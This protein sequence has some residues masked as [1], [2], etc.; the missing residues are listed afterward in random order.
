MKKFLC[1]VLILIMAMLLFA[2]C[3]PN[4]IE[5]P[6]EEFDVNIDVDRNTEATLR[7]L[8]PSTDGGQEEMYIKALEPGFKEMFPNVTIEYDRRAISDDK[9]V[10][11][12]SSAIASGEVPDLFYA[13][14][15][16][17]YYLVSQN[18][19]ISLEPYYAA[20]ADR[21]N[22]TGG[23]EGLN[24]DA[25]YYTSFFDMSKYEGNRY[26][27]PR[28]MDSVVTYYNTEF[29]QAAGISL[30]DER[31]VSTE[32]N[33]FTW[34]D[35]VSLCKD[36]NDFIVSE[37]GRQAGYGSAYALQADFDWEAVFNA[38]MES[39]GSQAFDENGNVAIDSPQ[40]TEMANM[41]RDL[42][43]YNGGRIVRSNT[44]GSSFTNGMTA[45]HFSSQ[46]PSRM[47]LNEEIKESFNAVPFPLIG[48]N[49]KI[50][51]GFAGW[52][53]SSTSDDTTRDIAWQFLKY[54]ISRE[55]Q[56]AL[57][58]AGLATPSI[59]IDLAEEKQW[60]KGYEDL[61]LDAWL[62]WE[63]YKV[64]SKFFVNQDPSATFDILSALQTFMRNLVDPTL[65]GTSVKSVEMCIATAK[66]DLSEAVQG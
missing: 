51:C 37:E 48:E 19:I 16:F 46:G 26:V 11:S 27:V 29:L 7:I 14:T 58:N 65:T 12:I 43:N 53:I 5:K 57:I 39:Y 52:G 18:C 55:G 63:E 33:P 45:F 59:R 49:P 61:N 60:S 62:Q 38:L 34:D 20:E 28:S 21:Y 13:N 3:Q 6:P 64:S 22:T 30:S 2:G 1:T 9:Y 15:V 32:E 25:D 36:V 35:L 23:Q 47:G 42:C 54:M 10:E 56:M 41:L 44:S 8:V 40:T 66:E 50:G 31:L 17:Y 4:I 24:L